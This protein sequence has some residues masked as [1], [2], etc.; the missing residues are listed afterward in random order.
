[1]A[2]HVDTRWMSTS[3]SGSVA[4]RA[5]RQ[6]RAYLLQWTVQ[7]VTMKRY[8]LHVV[9]FLDWCDRVGEDPDDLDELDDVLLDY[10]HELYE[11]GVGKS[12]ANLTVYGIY[13]FMPELKGMLPRSAAAVRAW[14]KT[15][16]GDSYPPLSW[17]LTVAIAVQMTRAYGI[18]YGIG[19]LLSFDCLLRVSELVN[20]RVRDVADDGDKRISSE[21][22]GM[23]LRLRQTKTGPNKWV[24]V[25]DGDCIA[26]MRYWMKNKSRDAYLFPF[27]TY[28]FRRKFKQ[29]CALLGLSPLYVPHSL[30]HGGATRYHHVKKWSVEDVMHRGRWQSTKSAKIYIQSGV[31]ML[32]HVDA[33][34]GIV[35]CG[36]CFAKHVVLSLSLAQ[37][38]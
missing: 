11:S 14:N 3:S 6:R 21:H 24:E 5:Q 20:L 29:Q 7:P 10:I 25:L 23:I 18:A 32:M 30:R 27:A 12:H 1:M 38:H 26:L 36:T 28:T 16:I 17:E 13:T 19:V 4:G 8:R 9:R 37:K 15:K 31:A 22:K 34:D 2:H 33:V 35:E